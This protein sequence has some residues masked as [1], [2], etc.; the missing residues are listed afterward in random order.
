MVSINGYLRFS[1]FQ[2]LM[3]KGSTYLLIHRKTTSSGISKPKIKFQGCS[4]KEGCARKYT[5]QYMVTDRGPY[6]S[7]IIHSKTSL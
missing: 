2:L 3:V 1:H 7:L 4:Y 6:L 5:F